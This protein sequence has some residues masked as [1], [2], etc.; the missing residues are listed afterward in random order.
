MSKSESAKNIVD[1][2]SSVERFTPPQ[3]DTKDNSVQKEVSQ[4]KDMPWV[5]PERF[6]YKLKPNEFKVHRVFL[7]AIKRS[8]ITAQFKKLLDNH[9][10]DYELIDNGISCLCSFQL[11]HYG[12]FILQ[13][14]VVPDYF[15]S[16]S[17]LN[18]MKE[19]PKTWESFAPGIAAK[20]KD[21][22]ENQCDVIQNRK[23]PFFRFTDLEE[24]MEELIKLSGLKDIRDLIKNTAIVKSYTVRLSEKDCKTKEDIEKAL[25]EITAPDSTILNSFY[26]SDLNLISQ[27]IEN[28]S[29]LGQTLREYLEITK[30]KI[31]QNFRND[32]NLVKKYSDYSYLPAARWPGS[33]EHSLSIAQQ[34]AVNLALDGDKGLFSVNGPPGTGKSTLLRDI[35]SGVIL[36]RAEA[37]AKFEKPSDAF[38]GK[39]RVPVDKLHYTVWQLDESLMGY[40]I[41]IASSNNNAVEN[42]SKEIPRKKEIDNS[43]ELDYFSEIGSNI[44]ETEASWG[45]GAAALGKK[46][47]RN[48][49]LKFFWDALPDKNK[50]TTSNKTKNDPKYGLK[51]LLNN[52]KPKSNWEDCRNKFFA[53]KAKFEKLIKELKDLSSAI[54]ELPKLQRKLAEFS[55]KEENLRTKI[56]AFE[57]Q[58]TSCSQEISFISTNIQD[59]T[60]LLDS[61][62]T[63][64]PAWYIILIDFFRKGTSYEDW[65]EKCTQIINDH[66]ALLEKKRKI[67]AELIDAKAQKNK[68]TRDLQILE[69]ENSETIK[70]VIQYQDIIAIMR[71][72]YRWYSDLPNEDFWSLSDAEVQMASPWMHKDLQDA[73]AELFVDAMNLHKSFIINT[74]QQI[75]RTLNAA[76]YMLTKRWPD[77]LKDLLPHIWS[78]FFLVVPA[79]STTFSSF[80]NLFNNLEVDSIGY[81][82]IDEAG[83]AT[84]QAAAGALYRA[85][86]AIIVGDPLQIPPVVTISRALD[87]ALLNYHQ[88]DEKWSALEESTQ[89][90]ADRVNTFGT[91]IGEGE[92]AKWVGCPLRVHRRCLN[93]MFDV[94]N[95]IAY[96]NLM[97]QATKNKRSVIEDIFPTSKWIDV[98][99][100]RYQ[101]KWSKEEGEIV[102]RIL[103]NIM[104]KTKELPLVYIIS[105]F[106]NVKN[107]MI[108]YLRGNQNYF[109]IL[110]E[111]SEKDFSDW[112]KNYVGTVHTFQ[113]KQ[114]D[115]VILL[116]G[117]AGTNESGSV[118]WASETPN[119][120]N[121][122][123]TRAKNLLFVVGSYD[124]W[125]KK[126]YFQELSH[127]LQKVSPKEFLQNKPKETSTLDLM[128]MVFE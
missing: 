110:A 83:Q 58:I 31:K 107:K 19:N 47:N 114:Q 111:C 108:G 74:S 43:Y 36:K 30:P 2:W 3:V 118:N 94:A 120:L 27:E 75:L 102:L 73:R 67:S 49:F 81:L 40:E 128:E 96:D 12:K 24:L 6:N 39:K 124:V 42:I 63:L 5:S 53:G 45:I 86:R 21:A 97:I 15:V 55:C 66:N 59:K 25:D 1:Y 115:A 106:R 11:T 46:T 88:T 65:N 48:D 8:D 125:A 33:S 41:V 32:Q 60:I 9:N 71:E 61:V 123:I 20:F 50:N 112:I 70:K 29:I 79:V 126:P 62:K 72:K 98:T 7:G 80:A 101:D 92:N 57:E 38:R 23:H 93:P 76:K 34:I 117:A 82:L 121:V 99:D 10:K 90:L 22:F 44:L 13:S 103:I 100:G 116:L 28:K 91:Y 14:D 26:T 119:I 85:K 51:Y 77:D 89:T 4:H 68:L 69:V 35:I 78:L 104:E 52:I 87:R 127:S 54:N 18:K 37:L 64:K 122:A 16:M 113:G 17:C 105:P 95:S 109:S 56:F 84:P